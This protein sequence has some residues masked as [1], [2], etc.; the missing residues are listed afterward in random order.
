MDD[1]LNV[2]IVMSVYNGDEEQQLEEAVQSLLCQTIMPNEIVVVRDGPVSESIQKRIN[3]YKKDTRFKVIELEKNHGSARARQA[4]I[5]ASTNQIIALMDADDI[6]V[7]DRLEI[8]LTALEKS[9]CDVI[10]GQIEEF[11]VK[12]GDLGRRRVVPSSH[13]E[14]MMFSKWRNPITNVTLMFKKEAFFKSGGYADTRLSEDWDFILKVIAA[15]F[16]VNNVSDTLVYVR[17]GDNMIARRRR[18]TQVFTEIKLFWRMYNTGNMQF[19]PAFA[20]TIIR[21]VLRALPRPVTTFLYTTVLR[22]NC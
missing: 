20:N 14:I 22:R 4:G 12:I 18:L 17:S 19:F 6:C 15:G 1:I 8:Q 7:V 3:S 16:S 21:L 11:D 13:E 5:E 9:G 2:T 10:G